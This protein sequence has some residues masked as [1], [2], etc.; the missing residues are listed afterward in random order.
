MLASSRME[1]LLELR[2]RDRLFSAAFSWF[3][4]RPQWSFGSDRIQVNAEIRLLQDF[5]AAIQNDH[6]RGDHHTSSLHDRA[7]AFL[8]KGAASLHEYS[9]LHRDRIRLLQLLVENEIIRLQVWCNPTNE[10]R[11]TAPIGTI[12]RNVGADEWP[13]LVQKAW[14]LSPGMAI[15]MGERF[16]HDPVQREITRLVR[17]EPKRVVDVPEALH[18]L[19]GERLEQAS[20]PALKVSRFPPLT[21]RIDVDPVASNLGGCPS[22]VSSGV[23][24][25]E[26]QQSPTHPTIWHAGF[27]AAPSRAYFLLR[28]AG[29]AGTP[30]GR[31]W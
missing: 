22:C 15:H 9:N 3:A 26:I 17:I 16:K 10:N 8:V 6:I 29:S 7:P 20:K 12:E 21:A 23:L 31:V 13:R 19:L 4:A 28:P 1:A 14:V 30:H 11:G 25:T 27:G 18:Y 2:F 5:L 24:P